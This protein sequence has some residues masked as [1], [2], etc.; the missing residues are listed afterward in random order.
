[1]LFRKQSDYNLTSKSGLNLR[2]IRA[3]PANTPPALSV[4]S[5]GLCRRRNCGGRS[6]RRGRSCRGRGGRGGRGCRGGRR[7]WGWWCR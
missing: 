5:T 2:Y 6:C 4:V 7:H 3:M 1:M